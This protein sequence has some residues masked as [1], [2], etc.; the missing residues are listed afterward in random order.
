MRQ[1]ENYIESVPEPFS[2]IARQVRE[3]ILQTVDGV[4][5]KFSYRVP[6]YYYYGLFAFMI[7]KK[8]G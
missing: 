5:E 6:V 8:E 7:Y 4:T 1:V 3:I 2:E